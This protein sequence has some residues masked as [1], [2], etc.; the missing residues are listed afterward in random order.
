MESHAPPRHTIAL[1]S[2]GCLRAA[3]DAAQ[4]RLGQR[5]RYPAHAPPV[6]T[7]ATA[8]DHHST[9]RTSAISAQQATGTHRSDLCHW[10]PPK[11]RAVEVGGLMPNAHGSPG[12]AEDS[13]RYRLVLVTISHAV[14]FR[15][16][17]SRRCRSQVPS[18]GVSAM[19]GCGRQE[20]PWL[21]DDRREAHELAHESRLRSAA[22]TPRT[23][24]W[25]VS[26]HHMHST[27]A[28]SQS[29]FF[30]SCISPISLLCASITAFARASSSAWLMWRNALCVS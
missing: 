30:F 7:R 4:E 20:R 17:C 27:E 5:L 13:R 23:D 28:L 2:A 12:S 10:L 14:P 19:N 11:M 29:S 26:C 1:L 9:S 16:G 21:T 3:R 24:G 15:L 6:R 25:F 22:N 8:Q 18:R